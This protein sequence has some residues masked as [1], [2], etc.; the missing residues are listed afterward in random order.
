MSETLPFAEVFRFCPRCGASPLARTGHHVRCPACG[1]E[2]YVNP[3]VAVGGIVVNGR[4]E[5]LF[6]RRARDPARGLLGMP[7]GFVDAGETAEDALKRE[8]R[9][10]TGLEIGGMEFLA[11]FPNLYRFAGVAYDVLD[12]FFVCR[13]ESFAGARAFDEVQ[14]LVVRDP[15]AIAPEEI[16]FPSMR[17]ALAAFRARQAS[18]TGTSP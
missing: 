6:L 7:G 9:E 18:P 1:H 3:A 5:G 8:A 11:S 2:H 12:L 16:A 4:G 10:E 15:A 14:E 17:R 13:V